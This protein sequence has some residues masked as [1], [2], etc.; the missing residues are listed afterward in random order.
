MSR[1]RAALE[2]MLEESRSGSGATASRATRVPPATLVRGDAVLADGG[3]PR[4]VRDVEPITGEVRIRFENG[5][6]V[7]VPRAL[8]LRVKR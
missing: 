2:R 6:G 4:I 7:V 5:S 3:E 8:T 1:H